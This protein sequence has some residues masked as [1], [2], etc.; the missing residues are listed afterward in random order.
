MLEQIVR[1][2]TLVT[3][4]FLI[5]SVVGVVA[6]LQTP[7]QMIPDLDVRTISVRTQWPGASPQDV[8]SE[9]LIEQEEFLRRVP[10]LSRLT[11][12]AETGEATIELEFPFDTDVTAALLAV[13]NALNQVPAYP[14]TVRRPQVVSSA[15]SS[16]SFMFFR[17]SPLPGN[18]KAVDMDLIADFVDRNV[19]S[20]M[21]SVPGVSNVGL[22][23]SAD[24]QIQIWLDRDALND[25]GLSLTQVRATA[26]FP[27]VTSIRASVVICCAP[28]VALTTCSRWPGSSCNG[29]AMPSRASATWQPWCSIMPNPWSGLR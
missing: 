9:V 28:S 11:A 1:Q 4:C 14:E 8:E 26:I 3:V 20:R 25:R 10:N 5:L 7:V 2:S 24:R 23:G 6:A 22:F 27:P 12:V 18:P 16:N 13:N 17:I 19:R 29:R 21:E 15:F